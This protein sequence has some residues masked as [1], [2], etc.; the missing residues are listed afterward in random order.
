IYTIINRLADEG[1]GVLVISSELPELIGI[2]DRIYALCEGR[3]TGEVSR[4]D[5]TQEL[6]MQYMTQ[7]ED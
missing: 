6:L 4:E 1:K 5:A 2:C 3:I 7:V